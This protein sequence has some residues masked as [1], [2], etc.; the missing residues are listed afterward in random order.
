MMQHW[1]WLSATVL[2][3]VWY[4][5][6]TIYVAVRGAVDIKHMLAALSDNRRKQPTDDQSGGAGK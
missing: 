2:V 4:S 5:S 3:V 6:I 1:F